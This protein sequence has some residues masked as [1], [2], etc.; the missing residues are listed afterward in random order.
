MSLILVIDDDVDMIELTKKY[1]ASEGYQIIAVTS[2]FDAEEVM[3]KYRINLA[4]VDINMPMKNGYDFVAQ[5]KRSV[6]N[7][8]VP[9]V[10]M[11]GRSEKKDI[12]RALKL[13]VEGYI[14]KPFS[15]DTLLEK[16]KSVLKNTGSNQPAIESVD[17]SSKNIV[18]TV[19]LEYP[20]K[21]TSITEIGITISSQ[22]DIGE[23][24]KDLENSVEIVAPI[25]AVVGISPVPLKVVNKVKLS[26]GGFELSLLFKKISPEDVDRLRLWIRKSL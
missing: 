21:V 3:E 4:L 26:S 15:K 16:V 13:D 24:G 11:S 7:R 9:I 8:F 22:V 17:L 14:V 5:L 1:L 2:P 20:I 10:F 18:G 19:K 12:E 23:V 6:R 25:W